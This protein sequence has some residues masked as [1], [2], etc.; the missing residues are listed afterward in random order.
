M[1]LVF[2]FL[3]YRNTGKSYNFFTIRETASPQLPAPS[4]STNTILEFTEHV[5]AAQRQLLDKDSWD[6]LVI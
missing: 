3:S 2:D 5:Q 1:G 4:K 6:L